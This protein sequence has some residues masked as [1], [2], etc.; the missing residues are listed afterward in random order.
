MGLLIESGLRDCDRIHLSLS[1]DGTTLAVVSGS[2]SNEMHDPFARV[3]DIDLTKNSWS[4]HVPKSSNEYKEFLGYGVAA[5]R[6]STQ[7]VIAGTTN[8]LLSK[9]ISI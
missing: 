4:E 3:Y 6:D 8:A 5:N 2:T 7:I 9:G 1:G